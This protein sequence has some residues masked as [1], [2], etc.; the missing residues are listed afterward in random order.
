MEF[1]IVASNPIHIPAVFAEGGIKNTIEKTLQV[2]QDTESFTWVIGSPPI[3]MNPIGDGGKAPKGQ[4]FNG[5]MNAICEHTVFGQSGGRY[6]WSQDV[7]DNYGGYPSG[8]IIQSDD[9][10]KEFRSLADNNTQNPNSGLGSTWVV[11]AGTGSVPLGTSTVAGLLKVLNTLTSTDVASALSAAQGKALKD[12]ID[13]KLDISQA[14]GVGQSWQNLTASRLPNITYTNNTT[15][16]IEV[17][18]SLPD[19]NSQTPTVSIVVGGVTIMSLNYDSGTNFGA[20]AF[21]FIVPSSATYRV[22]LTN[23]TVS[24]WSELR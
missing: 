17:S 8:A 16:P 23:G 19:T 6:K 7:I 11:Y 13:T 5:V 20:Q 12:L 18:I 9:E 3:T 14:L 2:G 10:T 15:R 24:N 4:D 1:S 21:T 22:N